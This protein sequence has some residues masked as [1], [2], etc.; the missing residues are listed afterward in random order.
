[1]VTT[2]INMGRPR[3]MPT[4]HVRMRTGMADQLMLIAHHRGK[5]LADLMESLFGDVVKS[6]YVKTID[7]LTKLRD[8][9]SDVPK[10]K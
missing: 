7:D 5:D 1:M 4:K 2:T 10:R 9:I 6:E 3:K 8:R